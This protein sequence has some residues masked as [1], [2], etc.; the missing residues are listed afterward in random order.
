M[1]GQVETDDI[2]IH[3]G[4]AVQVVPNLYST[5]DDG[6]PRIVIICDWVSIQIDHESSSI[7]LHVWSPE[8]LRQDC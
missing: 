5:R 1:L 4:A 7:L 8:V 2:W 6:Q 3:E